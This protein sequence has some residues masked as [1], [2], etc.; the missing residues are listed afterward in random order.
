MVLMHEVKPKSA[1]CCLD[2]LDCYLRAM[3]S[4]LLLLIVDLLETKLWD[5]QFYTFCS[6][7]NILVVAPATKNFYFVLLWYPRCCRRFYNAENL[8]RRLGST[9]LTLSPWTSGVGRLAV[10]RF[11]FTESLIVIPMV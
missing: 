7:R 1:N 3:I 4:L 9:V 11:K 10:C 2:N 8:R 5:V 6:K